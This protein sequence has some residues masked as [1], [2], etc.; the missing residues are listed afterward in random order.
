M[1]GFVR[2]IGWRIDFELFYVDDME[3]NAQIGVSIL[4]AVDGVE[5]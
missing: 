2:R 4:V 3:Q 5:M 1:E